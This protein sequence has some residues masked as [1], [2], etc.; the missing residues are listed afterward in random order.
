MVDLLP[1]LETVDKAATAAMDTMSE[2]TELATAG[3][4]RMEACQA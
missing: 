4:F 3:H 2:V 1:T